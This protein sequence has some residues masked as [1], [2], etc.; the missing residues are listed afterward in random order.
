MGSALNALAVAG[1]ARLSPRPSP[2][3][4]PGFVRPS[5]PHSPRADGAPSS[6]SSR[7]LGRTF[8]E[9][10]RLVFAVRR[11]A[12]RRHDLCVNRAAPS[13]HGC[14]RSASPTAGS[15]PA[16]PLMSSSRCRCS[17][18]RRRVAFGP[19]GPCRGGS[20][21]RTAAL[22][23]SASLVIWRPGLTTFRRRDCLSRAVTRAGGPLIA[24]RPAFAPSRWRRCLTRSSSARGAARPPVAA[25]GGWG[26]ACVPRVGREMHARLAC[27]RVA[28][29]HRA[30]GSRGA[31]FDLGGASRSRLVGFASE[32]RGRFVLTHGDPDPIGGAGTPRASLR[33]RSGTASLSA[34]SL[35]APAGRAVP[36]HSVDRA[37]VRPGFPRGGRPIRSQ[38][39]EPDWERPSSH[40]DSIVRDVLSASACCSPSTS[41]LVQPCPDPRGPSSRQRKARSRRAG[42]ARRI[43]HRRVRRQYLQ[44]RL[45]TPFGPGGR[46][47]ERYR[48][49]AARVQP[50]G[51]RSVVM[52]TREE[53][54]HLYWI[55]RG[56]LP[57]AKNT[58]VTEFKRATSHNGKEHAA[59][60]ADSR[61]EAAPAFSR[62]LFARREVSELRDPTARIQRRLAP[63]LSL[64]S[65]GRRPAPAKT[66]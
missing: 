4:N 21:C 16:F 61:T 60:Y 66:V 63:A 17:R 9:V 38:S 62:R 55:G 7:E 13:A 20:A 28:A 10:G 43:R 33:S 52:G 1:P 15:F 44:R 65:G 12:W 34:H 25:A 41:H 56:V 31:P 18:R 5:S 49:P 8:F 22:V 57:R 51:R 6:G 26:P 53:G 47:V 23:R 3:S 35:C 2:C 64:P 32:A 14:R 30:G 50:R 54:R 29:A 48:P 42:S 24:R 36:P 37:P 11:R 45:R 19:A 59:D 46:I 27:R 40:D 39:A 58:K